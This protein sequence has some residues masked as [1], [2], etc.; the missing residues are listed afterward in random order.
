MKSSLNAVIACALSTCITIQ[1]IKADSLE[2]YRALMHDTQ[3]TV[4]SMELPGFDGSVPDSLKNESVVVIAAHNSIESGKKNVV[5]GTAVAGLALGLTLA[6]LGTAAAGQASYYIPL[7]MTDASVTTTDMTRIKLALNDTSACNKFSQL[8]LSILNGTGNK[9][10]SKHTPNVI[11]DLMAGVRVIKSDGE[12][13]NIDIDS[14][15][16]ESGNSGSTPITTLDIKE[17][18]IPG[19]VPGDCLDLFMMQKRGVRNLHPGTF[20]IFAQTQYPTL[21]HTGKITIDKNLS[22][23]YRTLNGMP[24]PT[25]SIGEKKSHILQYSLPYQYPIEDAFTINLRENPILQISIIDPGQTNKYGYAQG[26]GIHPNPSFEDSKDLFLLNFD[27]ICAQ[28]KGCVKDL[29]RVIEGNPVKEVKNKLK[30]KQWTESQA[31]DYLFNVIMLAYSVYEQHYDHILYMVEFG[32]MLRQCGI[33]YTYAFVDTEIGPRWDDIF[34]P[35]Q[36][37]VML[38]LQKTGRLYSITNT[39]NAPGEI[40]DEFVNSIGEIEAFPAIFS[41]HRE[42][43]KKSFAVPDS[44]IG[45]AL[46][47]NSIEASPQGNFVHVMRHTDYHSG[48]KALASGL[49]DLEGFK[50]SL[51]SY[52]NKDAKPLSEKSTKNGEN[53]DM[54]ERYR[55]NTMLNRSADASLF[56]NLDNP[57]ELYSFNVDNYGFK[58][59][60]PAIKISTEYVLDGLVSID[61]DTLT[62]NIGQ[63][64]SMPLNT[65]LVKSKRSTPFTTFSKKYIDHLIIKAPDD[66]VFAV[67]E[68]DGLNCRVKNEIGEFSVVAELCEDGLKIEKL[69]EFYDNKMAST[70]KWSQLVNLYN[71]YT[72]WSSRTI[73]ITPKKVIMYM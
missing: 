16:T 66:H 33:E 40:T 24:E 71:A 65:D 19:L 47:E 1:P 50:D 14:L 45:E 58:P 49:L 48:M 6:V 29:L 7:N 57:Q 9:R 23:A 62:L 59:E 11:Q 41:T 51:F 8:D 34:F 13:I 46:V 4:W 31:A 70:D 60:D 64:T 68:I 21:C 28:G 52:L 67:E 3:E 42:K 32:E 37:N 38:K 26:K 72:D 53:Q 5:N 44:I 36:Y 43:A 18:S 61:N 56:H 2:E 73:R 25:D 20:Q 35:E 12:I 27:N 63:L 55:L 69:I 39:M 30:N 15:L 54:L 10:E 17:I 22:L